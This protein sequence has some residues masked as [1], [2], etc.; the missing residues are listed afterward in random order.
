M[1]ILILALLWAV[2]TLPVLAQSVDDRLVVGTVT[3]PPFS[4][5]QDGVE[6]GFSLDLWAEVA[7]DLGLQ[8]D[9]RRFDAFGDMLDAVRTGQVDAAAANISI[10]AEREA[11]MDFSQPIF[12][13]G[14]QIMLQPEG[15]TFSLLRAAI[16]P[17]LIGLL[18]MG[19]VTL[20]VLGMLM[21]VFERRHHDYFGKTP[22]EAAFPAFWWA[23]NILITG[24]LVEKTPRSRMGRLFGV[25]MVM[26]SLFIVSIFV[27]TIT[28]NLTIEALGSDVDGINDLDGRRVA[29]TEGSTTSAYLDRRGLSHQTYADFAALI[30]AFE[31][32][33]VDA[34]VFD[35]PLLA[36]YVEN[37]GRGKARLVD[38]VFQP[39]FYGIALPT[40]SALREPINRALLGYDEDGTY[41]Q[42]MRKWFGD[43]YSD[44]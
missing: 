8:Y 27:A 3:R 20:L 35:G 13:A 19:F 34:V 6:T 18:A 33:D 30:G 7:E 32:G 24:E 29:T 37:E 10:T 36:Y 22:R 38:R 21:W 4:L 15:G 43:I 44:R 42:I 9:I 2:S 5:V 39:E 41:P 40:G 11:E 14:I 17:R 16:S 1:R 28:A 31:A 23:L 26:S 12:S 25:L